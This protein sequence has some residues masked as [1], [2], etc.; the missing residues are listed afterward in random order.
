LNYILPF[1]P[2]NL[3]D[4]DGLYYLFRFEPISKLEHFF[5]DIFTERRVNKTKIFQKGQNDY[6]WLCVGY[7]EK[8]SVDLQKSWINI[9]VSH[10]F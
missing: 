10:S 4:S 6:R 1:G 8:D 5:F 7:S 2:D 9:L 3:K